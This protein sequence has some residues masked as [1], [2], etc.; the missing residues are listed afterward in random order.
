MSIEDNVL[1]QSLVDSTLENIATDYRNQGFEVYRDHALEGHRADLV[2]KKGEHVVIYEIKSGPWSEDKRREV[3]QRMASL[4]S[5][6]LEDLKGNQFRSKT[7]I[8]SW[9][10]HFKSRTDSARARL[11]CPLKTS[12]AWLRM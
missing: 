6:S 8:G 5:T 2:A 1:M 10:G 12:P 9:F 11:R 7:W 4:S 3:A